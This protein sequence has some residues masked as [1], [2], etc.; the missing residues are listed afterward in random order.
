M[1]MDM[2]TPQTYLHPKFTDQLRSHILRTSPDKGAEMLRQV[3][4]LF[5]EHAEHYSDDQ[6]HLFDDV[7]VHLTAIVETEARAVLAERLAPLARAPRKIV[8]LLAFD[9]EI[10]V[11]SPVLVQSPALDDETLAENARTQSQHHLL[12]ISRRTSLSI[13]ITDI[14]VG[15]GNREVLLSAASNSGARFSNNG[16]AALVHRS[17]GDDDLTACVANRPDI[18]AHLFRRLLATASEAV[19]AKL[20]AESPG[21]GH[22]IR[23]VVTDITHRLHAAIDDASD[24]LECAQATVEELHAAGRLNAGA[25]ETFATSGR[26]EESMAALALL[27][28]LPVDFVQQ[29]MRDKRAEM[30]LIIAKA[31]GLSRPVTKAILRLRPGKSRHSCDRVEHCLAVFDRLKAPTAR[32]ILDFYRVRSRWPQADWNAR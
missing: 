28:E 12:A 23:E 22:E 29:A 27:G 5:I 4:D 18:P 32:H 21:V 19:Q 8:R 16:F 24:R 1:G 30:L 11:A 6:A 31:L 20:E 15:R 13:K 17:E 7:L 26:F 14:L 25:V 3:S 9:N 10:R 2:S